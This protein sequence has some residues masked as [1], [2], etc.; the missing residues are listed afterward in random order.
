[1]ALRDLVPCYY[2]GQRV[3]IEPPAEE[4]SR[5][6]VRELKR[7]KLGMFVANGKFFLFFKAIARKV[8][9]LFD[10]PL[11]TGNAMPFSRR[12]DPGQHFH[13]DIPHAGD[14]GLW[15]HNRKRIRVSAR[16]RHST[17][18]LPTGIP[19]ASRALAGSF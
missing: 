19:A 10:G 17:E 3:G 6:E 13:Y 18:L 5:L 11:G 8:V 2:T 1:M 16:S 14:I 15:R 4:R 12:T 7:Q 9:R